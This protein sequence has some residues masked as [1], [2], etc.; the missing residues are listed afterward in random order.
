M[1]RT[2]NTALGAKIRQQRKLRG[3]TQ[4]QLG[5]ALRISFQQIQK[6]ERR[7]NT[8]SFQ[9]MVQLCE[10]L[11]VPLEFWQEEDTAQAVSTPRQELNLL[12]A[13]HAIPNEDH[14]TLLSALARALAGIEHSHAKDA[15]HG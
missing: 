5:D 15:H 1:S 3:L 8:L 11:N 7:Q 14:K 9:R 2:F 13:F 4:A 6:Y 12:R 10:A